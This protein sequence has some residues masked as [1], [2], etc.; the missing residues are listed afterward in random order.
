MKEELLEIERRAS[1]EIEAVR[2]LSGLEDFRITY[3]GKKS[4]VVS[5]MKQLKDLPSEERPEMGRL[6]NRIKK[7]QR[8]LSM[9]IFEIEILLMSP[10]STAS[11]ATPVIVYQSGSPL[12]SGVETILLLKLIFRKPCSLSV[13]SLKALQWVL[14]IQLVTT[15]FSTGRLG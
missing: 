14:M 5:A 10:P 12:V 9:L 6:A 4:V 11:T 15:T 8:T 13:P 1:E 2:D 3:L 7:G